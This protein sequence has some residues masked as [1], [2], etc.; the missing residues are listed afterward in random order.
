MR[1]GSSGAVADGSLEVIVLGAAPSAPQPD[2]QGSGLLVRSRGTSL[3]L[4]IGVGVVPQLGR[5]MDPYALSAILVTHFHADHYLDLV[6]YRYG[7]PWIGVTGERVPVLL[8]P[9]GRQQLEGLAAAICEGADFFSRALDLCE[10]D[11]AASVEVGDLAV[12]FVPSQHYV[13][14]WGVVVAGP[15]GHPRVVV[16]SD[17][18]PNPALVEASRD[19]DLLVAEATLE[20]AA[21]DVQPRGHLTADEAVAIGREAGARRVLLTHLPTARRPALRAAYTGIRP[22]VTVARPGLRITLTARSPHPAA[23]AGR[24]VRPALP[25]DGGAA[26]GERP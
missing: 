11:P 4:D 12:S 23:S 20:H 6:S 5:I 10:Y 25:D 13:D 3:L 15:G 19:A 21:E 9:G 17:T 1:P 14:A 7:L 8:P 2:G 24:A 16:S 18:G 22:R 26:S